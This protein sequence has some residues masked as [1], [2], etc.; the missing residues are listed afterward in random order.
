MDT[1]KTTPT[2][3]QRQLYDKVLGEFAYYARVKIL[4][5]AKFSIRYPWGG[6]PWITLEVMTDKG[7]NG[8]GLYLVNGNEE[9]IFDFT[10]IR[11]WPKN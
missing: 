8:F 10:H 3:Q 5:V 1:T 9:G 4:E 7:V 2:N 11:G 6:K